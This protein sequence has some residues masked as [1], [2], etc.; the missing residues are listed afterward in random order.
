MSPIFDF[1]CESCDA[2]F[3]ELVSSSDSSPACPECGSQKTE[4]RPPTRVSIGGGGERMPAAAF[5]SAGGG[6]CGGACHGH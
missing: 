1:H 3:E 2:G 4:R 5:S 6:C